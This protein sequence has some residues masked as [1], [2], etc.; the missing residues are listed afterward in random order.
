MTDQTDLHIHCKVPLH[1]TAGLSRDTIQE[2]ISAAAKCTWNA[3]TNRLPF[4]SNGNISGTPDP[5]GPSLF[6][7]FTIPTAQERQATNEVQGLWD[8]LM[9]IVSSEG[10]DTFLREF[11]TGRY[12]PME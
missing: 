7:S 6:F 4:A 10:V 11:R 9:N 2:L 5:A 12:G 3:I 1:I 8:G